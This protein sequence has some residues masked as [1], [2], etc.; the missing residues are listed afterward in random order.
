MTADERRT[1]NV[2][3][4]VAGHSVDVPGHA[5]ASRDVIPVEELADL[6]AERLRHEY[7]DPDE[8][9]ELPGESLPVMVSRD[10]RA[11]PVEGEQGS[12]TEIVEEDCPVCGYDRADHSTHTLAGVHRVTCRACGHTI[13]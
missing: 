7:G 10:F 11:D 13:E 12:Y 2:M 8:W 4:R 6:P 3:D 5:K 9:D 1:I